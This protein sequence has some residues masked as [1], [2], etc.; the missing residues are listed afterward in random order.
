MN[1]CQ[2]MST[3]L[4][5]NLKYGTWN[6]N[7]VSVSHLLFCDVLICCCYIAL[8]AMELVSFRLSHCCVTF[9]SQKFIPSMC[10][11]YFIRPSHL[12]SGFRSLVVMHNLLVIR[13]DLRLIGL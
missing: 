12:A 2:V 6:N 3:N 8:V 5:V 9:L 4:S 11:A 13:I 1:V 7:G 10:R